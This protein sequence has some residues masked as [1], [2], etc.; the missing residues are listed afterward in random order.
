MLKKFLKAAFVYPLLFLSV[1]FTFTGFFSQYG[2]FFD[3]TSHFRLQYLIIQIIC[4]I[5]F[6]VWQQRRRSCAIAFVALINLF[7]IIPLYLEV[8]VNKIS[9]EV[10]PHQLKII[11]VNVHTSNRQFGKVAEYIQQKQ[12]DLVALEEINPEWM[13]ALTPVLNEFPYRQ[14]ELRT[15]NFGI[16]LFSKIKPE[17]MT[18]E[19]FGKVGV[20][21]VVARFQF[22]EKP[23]SVL[24]T[25][26]VPPASQVYY[27]YR[28]EQMESIASKREGFGSN[29]IV[30]GD[31]NSTSWSDYFH[32]FIR[33]MN[34][35]DSRQGFG[36]QTTW[37]AMM[38]FLAI[39]IDHCLVS[40]NMMVIDRKIG[41]D[42]GS[43]HY[44]LYIE[45]GL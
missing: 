28:N 37:P 9:S 4:V 19:Y 20:P 36:L 35:I 11:L 23:L 5:G 21:S 45:I 6:F 41:P 34:L 1:F 42:V 27:E 25:H 44:P 43:D 22:E 14:F 12:P 13:A 38:P 30:I 10:S 39:T 31:F 33:K 40:P 2:L 7:Q 3:L 16:G 24:L 8:P 17:T 18:L 32:N 26:P 29:L 15:D